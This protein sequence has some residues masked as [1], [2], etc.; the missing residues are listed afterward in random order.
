[1]VSVCV[2]KVSAFNSSLEAVIESYSSL[3]T[4]IEGQTTGGAPNPC[5]WNVNGTAVTWNEV[6]GYWQ[7]GAME[8][9][10]GTRCAWPTPNPAQRRPRSA[11]VLRGAGAA[12]CRTLRCCAWMGRMRLGWGHRLTAGGL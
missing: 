11:D 10:V 5:A 2:Q 3:K 8:E 4:Y 12:R 1:M 7:N 6:G 9:M